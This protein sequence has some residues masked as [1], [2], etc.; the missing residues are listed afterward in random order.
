MWFAAV[1]IDLDSAALA[2]GL[3]LGA[4]LEDTRYIKPD[5]EP[6]RIDNSHGIKSR[7]LRPI[8]QGSRDK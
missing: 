2:R 7:G 3:R 8:G 1:P 5:I 6:Y 4:C